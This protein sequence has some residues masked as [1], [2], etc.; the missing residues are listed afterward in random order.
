[1]S[2]PRV[3]RGTGAPPLTAVMAGEGERTGTVIGA[4]APTTHVVGA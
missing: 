3:M 1:M 2:I 4:A